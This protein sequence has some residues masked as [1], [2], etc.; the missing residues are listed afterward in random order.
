MIRVFVVDDERLVRRGIIFEV[1]KLFPAYYFNSLYIA[2]L[3]VIGTYSCGY[4]R[5][6]IC[7]DKFSIK[8]TLLL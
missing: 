6:C 2:L 1:Q 4:F 3:V 7:K 8:N 5:I